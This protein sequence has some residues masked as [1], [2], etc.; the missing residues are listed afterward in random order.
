[1]NDQQI[2][3]LIAYLQSIQLDPKKVQRTSMETYGTNGAAI[4]DGMCGRCHTQGWSYGEAGVPGGG[5]YGPSLVGGATLRQFPA[6]EGDDGHIAFVSEGVE[7]GEAYG[8]RGVQGNESGGMPHFGAMLTPEQV[9][10]VVEY[11]R[12]L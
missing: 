10:A 12:S 3:D 9:R 5:G 11:E 6:V 7:F 8:T 4:F 2:D 1:M